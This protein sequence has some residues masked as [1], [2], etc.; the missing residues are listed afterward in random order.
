MERQIVKIKVM[1]LF[2]LI[3]SPGVYSQNIVDAKKQEQVLTVGGPNAD[4]PGFSSGAIQIALDA[5]NSRGGGTV[6]LNTGTF[7]VTAPLCIPANTSLIGSGPET[8]LK[9]CDG[10]RTGIVNDAGYG[11]LKVRAEDAGGFRKG[12]GIQIYDDNRKWGWDVTTA[13]ITD[14]QGDDIYLDNITL[15][16]YTTSANAVISNGCSVVCVVDVDNVRIADIYIEGNK[17][18][19]DYINGCRGGGVYFY[20]SK[21][22]TVENVIVNRFNGDGFSW[23]VTEKISVKGCEAKNNEK[24]GF[25]PGSGSS[26]SIIENCKSHNNKEW[27]IHVCSRVKNGVFRNNEIYA[28]GLHGISIGYQDT[29]NLFERNHIYENG[30]N[31]I[32]FR[33]VNEQNGA[34]RNTIIDNIIENNGMNGKA[35]GIYIGGETKDIVI[36]KNIIRSTGTGNQSAAIIVGLKS[37]IVASDNEIEG[38]EGM[39]YEK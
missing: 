37:S 34:H 36:Q 14:I 35:V 2:I 32:F 1:V 20:R 30:G 39:I 22:C 21:N 17:E 8:I 29:D 7:D 16:D 26:Y 24:F 6:K 10:F 25:H 5:V 27:G 4:I 19:N 31:G 13:I 15:R 18:T 23:Q 12:M 9:K 28:N 38:S 33:N 3:N 11:L